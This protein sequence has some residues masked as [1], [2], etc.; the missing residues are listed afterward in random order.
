MT[1]DF[2][3][4]LLARQLIE[5]HEYPLN[6]VEIL[7]LQGIWGNFN[8]TEIGKKEDYSPA[9][10]S[11][12]AAPKLYNKLSKLLG[13]NVTKKNCRTLLKSYILLVSNGS[14]PY[15]SGAVPLNSLLYIERPPIEEQACE[16]I[17][18]LGAL[19]RIEAPKEMGKTSLQRQNFASCC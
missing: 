19:I 6:A 13:E 2:L 14:P 17:N 3:L 16:E 11:N 10:L 12:V 18:K 9:Y 7:L 8:Y 5:I 4:N 1:F 15:P